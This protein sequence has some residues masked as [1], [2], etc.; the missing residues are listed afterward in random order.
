MS[1]KYKQY[2]EDSFFDKVVAIV[3]DSDDLTP[4]E[5]LQIGKSVWENV[6]KQNLKDNQEEYLRK[7]VRRLPR[8]V[9]CV[10]HQD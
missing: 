3:K 2:L 7:L 10:R 8:H 1:I 5:L 9:I 6:D 4:I